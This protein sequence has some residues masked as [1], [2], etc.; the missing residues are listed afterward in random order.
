MKKLTTL[1]IVFP[2]F[3][4]IQL[5]CSCNTKAQSEL[6][7]TMVEPQKNNK[8]KS[9]SLSITLRAEKDIY[10]P[11]EKINLQTSVTNLSSNTLYIYSILTWGRSASL[12]LIVADSNGKPIQGKFLNDSIPPPPRPN[13][14]HS[15]VRLYPNHFLGTKYS[16]SLSELNID[17]P[18]KYL[19]LVEY[20][21]PILANS[22]ELTPFWGKENGVVQSN[23]VSIEVVE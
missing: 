6:R 4:V 7:N 8:D 2:I 13:D 22:V 21:S 18:G 9:N 12:S 11:E 19:L 10:K 23:T 3:L 5:H 14:N 16:A 17:K 1:F 15:F 20:H